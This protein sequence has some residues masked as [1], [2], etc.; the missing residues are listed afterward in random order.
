MLSVRED[1]N[2]CCFEEGE[3]A[4]RARHMLKSAEERKEDERYGLTDL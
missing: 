3:K 1:G 2:A 4:A